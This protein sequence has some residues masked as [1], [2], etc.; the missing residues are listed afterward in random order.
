MAAAPV[1]T[2]P[3]TGGSKGWLFG[4]PDIDLAER[5]Y[6]ED[7]FFLEGVAWRY[8]PCPGATLD[9]DGLWQVEPVQSSP[10][11]TRF[12]VYRPVDPAAFNGTVL[13]SW[14]NVSAG[15]DGYTADSPEVLDS[16]FAYVAVTV[17]RAGV[18]G[19]GDR[20]MGLVAWDPE[21]YGSLSIPSDDYSYDIFTQAAR[22]VAADRPRSPVDP[23]DGLAP[24][25][26]Q[27]AV[28]SPG[29]P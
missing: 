2:G 5:A 12:V 14:N 16:G 4:R 27:R 8:G 13:V 20:P 10:Y 7:E 22:A 17:Q 29:R 3:V 25:S 26:A 28:P 23:L 18:H 21:R 24:R 19:M 9:R 1:V 11:T 6:R 15:F